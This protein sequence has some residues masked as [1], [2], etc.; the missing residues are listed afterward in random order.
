MKNISCALSLIVA[1]GFGAGAAM[2]HTAPYAT[3]E[4]ITLV[5]VSKTMDDAIPQF[6]W[7][8]L[9]DAAGKPL[10]TS[11]ADQ[12]GRSNCT[13]ACVKEFE[14]FAAGAQAQAAGDF[15]IIA[16]ADGVKQWA[17]QGKA[18]Y[19]F[20]GKDP[21]GQ[22]AGARF[23]AKEDPKW[24]DPGSDIYSP[25]TGWRRAAFTPDQTTVMPSTVELDD[26]AVAGGYAFVDAASGMTIYAAPPTHQLSKDWRPVRASALA[27]PV[28]D[29][30]VVT[31]SDD[32]SRQWAYKGEALYT[33]AGD[34]ARGEVHGIFAGDSNVHAALAYKNFTP[35]GIEVR[36]YPGR[37]PLMTDSAG[38]S[39]YYVS[40]Y[41]L[42][43]G[44][45]ET[46]EG[47][48]ITYND[49]KAQGAAACL[50]ECTAS[51]KPMLAAAKDQGWGFWEIVDRPDGTRQWAFKGSPVYTFIGDAKP[52]DL[53]GNNRYVILYGDEKGGF[54]YSN[55]GLD[56]RNP[57]APQ[58]ILG[59]V[60]MV[61]ALEGGGGA[62][63]RP[64]REAPGAGFYWHAVGLFY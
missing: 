31:R 15:S 12:P 38:M 7:R 37:G 49:A 23:I 60:E 50:G 47:H 46:R 9:G 56:P 26:L 13:A 4:G 52:G 16:R 54:V 35:T 2:A 21:A 43:Y 32:R 25:K 6:L 41:Q 40:R 29:F 63:R 28:G 27:L 57:T 34:Y 24:A 8:R 53:E 18:L 10:Y 33:Y 64:G 48:S 58:P 14:P 39:L 30:A 3:P 36:E 59:S 44:G 1:S 19:R 17:Y 62:D 51:W 5:N 42:Q 20:T 22:P 11:D 61:T 55:P 45:R